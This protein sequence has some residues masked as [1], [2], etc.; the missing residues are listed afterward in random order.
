MDRFDV[1]WCKR[2]LSKNYTNTL[3]LV[4]ECKYDKCNIDYKIC[5]CILKVPIYQPYKQSI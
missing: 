3:N 5:L 1:R 4:P 2:N